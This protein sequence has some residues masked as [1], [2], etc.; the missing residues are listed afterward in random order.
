[1]SAISAAV[2]VG[3]SLQTSYPLVPSLALKYRSLFSGVR[4]WGTEP[5]PGLMFV[6]RVAAPVA[7]TFQSS[8]SW[9]PSS[10]AKYSSLSNTV[11]PC[12]CDPH[13]PPIAVT[14]SA[15]P[16]TRAVMIVT[17]TSSTSPSAASPTGVR[18][19]AVLS[20]KRAKVSPSMMLA[21]VSRGIEKT[22]VRI[23]SV[24]PRS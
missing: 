23:P 4:K 20:R 7:S 12:G 11:N 2:P 19:P 17:V 10:A 3:S 24:V 21:P 22:S 1:M 18:F 13:S 5:P 6:I 14:C 15:D 16:E 8:K 9:A